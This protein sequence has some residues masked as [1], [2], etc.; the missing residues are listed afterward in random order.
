ML[1]GFLLALPAAAHGPE[2]LAIA[3]ESPGH[4]HFGHDLPDLTE[5]HFLVKTPDGKSEEVAAT[6]AGLGIY[7]AVYTLNQQGDYTAS[8]PFTDPASQAQIGQEENAFILTVAQPAAAA[9]T[10]EAPSTL[11]TT[12]VTVGPALLAFLLVAAGLLLLGLGIL[13]SRRTG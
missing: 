4:W 7:R 10:T 3:L 8:L 6:Y 9:A 13:G 11:P 2:G 1:L 12:G 5:A